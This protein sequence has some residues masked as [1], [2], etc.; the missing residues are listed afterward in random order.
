MTVQFEDLFRNA[1]EVAGAKAEA[2]AKATEALAP[3]DASAAHLD[4]SYVIDGK[5]IGVRF[6]W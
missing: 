5:T 2:T 1:L 6:V 3:L 4:E